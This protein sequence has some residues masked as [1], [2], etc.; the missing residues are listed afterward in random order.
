MP[1]ETTRDLIVDRFDRLSALVQECIHRQELTEARIES[2]D[3]KI[4]QRLNDTRPIWEA[5]QRRMDD[6][7]QR[8]EAEL[9]EVNRQI[10]ELRGEIDGLRSE[11]HQE[12]GSIRTETA[13]GYRAVERKIGIL[14]K[15]LVDMTA[16]I[17]EIQD[18][19]ERL[20]TKPS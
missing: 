14:S 5:L 4:E 20:E 10:A 19:L 15:N 9:K 1:E 7:D 3:Q 8:I 6:M 17:R 18:R 12:A 16:D 13:S 2:L 11:L